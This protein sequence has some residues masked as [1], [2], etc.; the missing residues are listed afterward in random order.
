VMTAR[1][2]KVKD[3]ISIELPRP[4]DRT[5]PEFISVRGKVLSVLEAEFEKTRIRE[6][7]GD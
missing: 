7:S 3:I 4:R 5:S 6:L 1:P 2:G